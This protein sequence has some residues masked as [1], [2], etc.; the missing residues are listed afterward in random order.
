MKLRKLAAMLAA[1]ALLATLF[2]L[3]VYA[4]DT[5]VAGLSVYS[6]EKGDEFSG[7][8]IILGNDEGVWPFSTDSTGGPVA[9]AP[10]S[11]ASY[12]L[13]FEA[14]STGVE[15]FRVRWYKD[16]D[17]GS[18][19]AADTAAVNDHSFTADDV[20]DF[21]PTDLRGTIADGET[22]TYVVEFTLD[23]S[24]EAEGLIGNIGIRGASGVHDFILNYIKVEKIGGATLV[25]YGAP[26]VASTAPE[27]EPTPEP[28]V[29]TTPAAPATGD[30]FN[31][32][33]S[34]AVLLSS[35]SL[36][37]LAAKRGKASA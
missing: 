13:T 15:G 17:Y 35:V 8:N 30:G 24:A 22:K 11:D 10:E 6:T 19:T 21:I 32:G 1:A 31:L 37:V 36:F 2:V 3:P 18:A 7:A 27:P 16:N 33:L 25:E 12:R 34:L 26:T 23:G 28:V 29:I 5:S 20:A 4:V 14:K 9:F